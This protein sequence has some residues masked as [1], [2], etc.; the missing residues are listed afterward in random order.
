M[1]D[2]SNQQISN[3]M[4][5]EL[6]THASQFL[7]K[8][9]ASDASLSATWDSYHLIKSCLQK[10][11][12][13]PLVIDVASKVTQQ[14]KGMQFED[15]DV[16]ENQQTEADKAPWL[17]VL[18][19]IL[20]LGIAASVAFM[21][22]TMLQQLQNNGADNPHFAQTQGVAIEV[23][24]SAKVAAS[25]STLVPPPSL[26]RFPSVSSKQQ[27]YY[28]QGLSQN[29]NDLPYMIINQSNHNHKNNFSPIKSE[30]LTD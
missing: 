4:D 2:K 17:K 6:E 11:A 27:G 18:K 19:P 12:Q 8:R 7:L 16:Q 20:G 30:G 9:M 22:V 10:E 1:S 28:S 26:S 5:G 14:L 29:I 13:E 24:L 21:S 25:H 3:L 15:I 23:P